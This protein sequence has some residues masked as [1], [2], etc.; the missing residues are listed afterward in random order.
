M[1]ING[2]ECKLYVNYFE[3][4]FLSLLEKN[5]FPLEM[6]TNFDQC[7]ALTFSTTIYIE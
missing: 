1:L 7:R 3:R 6:I 2:D 4:D 5:A